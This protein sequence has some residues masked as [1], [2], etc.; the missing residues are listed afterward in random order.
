MGGAPSGDASNGGYLRWSDDTP[1][2]VFGL[3][4]VADCHFPAVFNSRHMNV[5]WVPTLELNIQIRQRPTDGFLTTWFQ[6]RAITGGYLEEDG[7]V[8]DANGHLIVLSRQLALQ[9]R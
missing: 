1:M 3:L 4:V 2:D 9:S 7:E 6:T 5:G 8:W